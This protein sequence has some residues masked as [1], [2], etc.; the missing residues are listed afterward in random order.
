[1]R[2]YSMCLG[3]HR[4]W[5]YWKK[6]S[7]MCSESLPSRAL[8]ITEDPTPAT[9]SQCGTVCCDFVTLSHCGTVCRVA[10][11]L[12]Y[13]SLRLCRI[14]VQFAATSSH[15]GTVCCDIVS[16]W[17]FCCGSPF[18]VVIESCLRGGGCFGA[19]VPQECK[20]FLA[21]RFSRLE[22]IAHHL[23]DLSRAAMQAAEADCSRCAF[24]AIQTP[25]SVLGLLFRIRIG[26]CYIHSSHHRI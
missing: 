1:M 23:R 8:S 2:S 20:A 4:Q 15:C 22:T 13:S 18:A 14:V 6:R 7:L 12:W 9:L 24:A 3:Y 10:D 16:L 21:D 26:L 11:A 25:N 19:H 17:Y 5:S